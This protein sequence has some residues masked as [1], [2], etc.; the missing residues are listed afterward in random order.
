MTVDILMATYNGADYLND[1]IQSIVNQNYS[2]W[3][4]LISDDDIKE[5]STISQLASVSGV[6]E[7]IVKLIV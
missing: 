6:P 2:D 4:L 1:Q 3:D 5:C 7:E